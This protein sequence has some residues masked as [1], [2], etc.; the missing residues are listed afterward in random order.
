MRQ[1]LILDEYRKTL[2]EWCSENMEVFRDYAWVPYY[3]TKN[4]ENAFR[5]DIFDD[6]W[7]VIFSLTWGN[8]INDSNQPRPCGRSR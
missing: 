7:A 3:V 6:E 1:Y 2:L 5:L 8:L 4:G